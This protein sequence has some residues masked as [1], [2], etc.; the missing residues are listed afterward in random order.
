MGMGGKI[1][2]SAL[3]AVTLASPTG[4]L[5]PVAALRVPEM[6]PVAMAWPATAKSKR[7]LPTCQRAAIGRRYEPFTCDPSLGSET[8]TAVERRRAPCPVM[9]S[10]PRRR[11]R[12]PAHGQAFAFSFPSAFFPSASPVVRERGQSKDGVGDID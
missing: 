3:V 9:K 2:L 12:L 7:A 10:C 5:A 11:Q 8:G 1:L 6:F 4:A